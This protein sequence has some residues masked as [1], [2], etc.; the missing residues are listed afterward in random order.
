[1]IAANIPTLAYHPLER[2]PVVRPVDRYAYVRDKCRGLRVL[3]LIFAAQVKGRRP[4]PI[5]K[6]RN[7]T[8]AAC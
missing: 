2:L 1:M 3:D 6:R 4:A 5:R 7:E 8:Q